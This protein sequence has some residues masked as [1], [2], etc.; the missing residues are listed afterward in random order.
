MKTVSHGS[1]THMDKAFPCELLIRAVFDMTQ[2]L[3]PLVV[4]NPLE[5]IFVSK[6][7]LLAGLQ[8]SA[9]LKNWRRSCALCFAF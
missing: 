2:W 9:C 3:Y 1:N 8:F 7:V 5:K 4:F 6:A